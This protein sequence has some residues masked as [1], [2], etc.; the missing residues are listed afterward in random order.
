MK[1]T[2][3]LSDAHLGSLAID[4]PRDHERKLVALLDEIFPQAKAIFL[5]GDIFDFYFE[6]KKTVPKLPA[7]FIGKLAQIA[8]AGVEIHFFAGN[9][10]MWHLDYFEKEIGVK[11]H[12]RAEVLDIAGKRFFLAHGHGLG[13]LSL[14]EKFINNF[15][16]S[17]ICQ[18]LFRNFIPANLGMK[19][20]QKWSAASRRKHAKTPLAYQGEENEELVK[21]AKSHSAAHPEIDFYIF[22][23]R[24]ILLHLQLSQKTQMV[25]LGDCFEAFNYAAFDGEMMEVF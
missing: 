5:L 7:R 11:L 25:I 17:K 12:R 15:F 4:N 20:G 13:R 1:K 18:F 19:I 16:S 2:F 14:G 23:H 24:H 9:H 8:D 6:Y 3:F 21:F 10:D 22:G